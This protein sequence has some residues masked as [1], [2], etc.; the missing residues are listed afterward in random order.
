VK[1]V[2]VS[3]TVKQEPR[4]VFDF[5]AI[6]ANHERF[7]DHMLTEWSFSGPGGGV[8]A[9]GRA[10]ANTPASQDWTEF[11]I[12]EAEAPRRLVEKGIGAG[13]KR[14]TR[15]TYTLE[16]LGDGGTQVSFELAWLEASRAERLL[17][18]LS[19]AFVRRPLRIAMRRLA[20][21]LRRS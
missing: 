11:E 5:L 12:V 16:P 17:P 14:R 4:E 6:L 3:V 19:R 18:A 15:G 2:G 9:K 7:L 8:G 10:R 13:G 21:E 20:K 1:P